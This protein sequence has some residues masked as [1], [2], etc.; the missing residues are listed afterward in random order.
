MVYPTATHALDSRTPFDSPRSF[1]M[2]LQTLQAA[3]P[4]L[5]AISCKPAPPTLQKAE[6]VGVVVVGVERGVAEAHPFPE[7][8]AAELVVTRRPMHVAVVERAEAE[9]AQDAAR[10]VTPSEGAERQGKNREEEGVVGKEA[11]A[12]KV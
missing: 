1:H 11:V 12:M 2:A 3:L 7:G 10:L 6:R 4:E 9:S 5:P 8:E